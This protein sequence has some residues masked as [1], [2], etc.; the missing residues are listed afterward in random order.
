MLKRRFLAGQI[1]QPAAMALKIQRNKTDRNDAHGLAQLVRTGWFR[2]VQVKS[3]DSH[4]LRLLLTHRRT[5]KRKLLDI[6]NEVRQSLKVF[7]LLLGPRVQRSTFETRVRELVVPD[8]LIAGVTE[9]MLRAWSAL[10]S[11]YKRLH[12]LL[13]RFVGRDER[14]RRFMV[15]PG[16]GVRRKRER[17]RHRRSRHER[18]ARVD[19]NTYPATRRRR[20]DGVQ[21]TRVPPPGGRE[22]G[23]SKRMRRARYLAGDDASLETNSAPDCLCGP[24]IPTQKCAPARYPGKSTKDCMDPQALIIVCRRRLSHR[25]KGSDII[26]SRRHTWR[27][28]ERNDARLRLQDKANWRSPLALLVKCLSAHWF[29]H[30]ATAPFRHC[31]RSGWRR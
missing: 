24:A 17:R 13:V 29:L 3:E 1:R 20:I 6:E 21:P 28:R 18:T 5:L 4:R 30:V 8:R 7:G 11:E 22:L 27:R 25:R 16:V 14:C 23:G 2:P 19:G 26:Q 31:A 15:I 9:C 12:T 10:W